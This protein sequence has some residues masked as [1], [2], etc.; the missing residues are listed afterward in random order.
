MVSKRDLKA[1]GRKF[2]VL[3]PHPK[4]LKNFLQ[5]PNLGVLPIKPCGL[6]SRRIPGVRFLKIRLQAKEMKVP[7][8]GSRQRDGFRKKLRMKVPYK[9]IPHQ[10][11]THKG[12]KVQRFHIKLNIASPGLKVPGSQA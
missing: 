3:L 12:A 11:S 1:G 7:R 5:Q 9:K 2:K 10:G 4:V 6:G 8:K